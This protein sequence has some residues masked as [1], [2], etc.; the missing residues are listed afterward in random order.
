[1]YNRWRPKLIIIWIS[2]LRAKKMKIIRN[3]RSL[4]RF[5][6]QRGAVQNG[7]TGE[8]RFADFRVSKSSW[9]VDEDDAVLVPKLT[10]RIEAMT[11]LSAESAEEFEIINYGLGGHYE[12]HVDY[13]KVRTYKIGQTLT[14]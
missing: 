14:G 8:W 7:V 3:R 6:L 10:K 1:M 4:F 11:G 13:F 9:L 2:T 5:Q 12:P